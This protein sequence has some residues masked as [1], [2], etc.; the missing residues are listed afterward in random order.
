MPQEQPEVV[1]IF[2]AAPIYTNEPVK[3]VV[4]RICDELPDINHAPIRSLEDMEVF[5]RQQASM[6]TEALTTN[7]PKGTSDRLIIELMARKVSL[8]RGVERPWKGCTTTQPF[9]FERDSRE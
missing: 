7:L 8:Y 4:I 1:L 2:K 6:L 5:Y 3:G 9:V